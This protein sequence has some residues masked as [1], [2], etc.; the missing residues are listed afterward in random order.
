MNQLGPKKDIYDKILLM[1]SGGLD[2]SCMIKWLQEKYKSKIYTFT[3]DLGQEFADPSRF[4]EI[5]EKAFNLGVENHHIVDLK[6][7][8]VNEYIFPTIKANGLYQ[9]VYPL[10]TAIGR[11]LIAIEAIKIA[12]K[13]QIDVIAHGCTGKGNDQI[14]FNVT[15]KAFDPNIEILQPLIE[16]NMGR[17]EEI[18]FAERHGI[19][20]KK[21]NQ[22]YSVDE[23]LFGRSAECDILEYPEIEPPEDCFAW[24]TS[25]ENAPDTAQYIQIDFEKGIP[26]G[27]NGERLHGVELIRQLHK[28]GCRHGIGRVNHIED[29][30]IGLKSRE[31]YEIPAALILIKAHK[32]LEKYVCTKHENSF[33]TIIDQRW[34]ELIYEGLWVDPLR[35]ALEAFINTVNEKVT[36]NVKLKLFK[37][38]V[39]VISRES[40]YGLYDLNLATYDTKSTFNQKFSY[41]FI[42]L[43]GL[44][45]EIGFQVKNTI[46][47]LEEKGSNSQ[48]NLIK[49]Q[50]I[51]QKKK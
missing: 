4:E 7:V 23:N 51:A 6:E 15:I 33:K 29:R 31:V 8:F 40:P 28:I 30:A 2:T 44:Q 5:E 50:N 20:I 17:D 1:Y 49:N 27:L 39:S 38:G 48:L 14:R 41:G 11:P 19:P 26:V 47:S 35:D 32:D 16:W 9:G 24:T 22:K 43:W 13:E 34:T 3:A 45:S 12:K 10:S 37:G 36:G 21:Q 42:P 18:K 46:K 25:P